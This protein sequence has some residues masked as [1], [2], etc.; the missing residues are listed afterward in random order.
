[1]KMVFNNVVA[2]LC[3][4]EWTARDI[5]K[6]QQMIEKEVYDYLRYIQ[7]PWKFEF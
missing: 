1:M 3:K 6:L 7:R 4:V 5:S 2:L